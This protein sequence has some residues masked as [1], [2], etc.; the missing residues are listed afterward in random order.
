MAKTL[1]IVFGIVL[2]LV[3]VMGFIPNQFVGA[4]AIFSTNLAHDLV[5]LVSGL[6]LL[7]VAFMAS[8]KSGTWLKILGAVYLLIAVLGFVMTPDGGELLGLVQ[9]NMTD[10]LLHVV[11]GVVLLVAGFVGKGTSAAPMA[12]AAPTPPMGGTM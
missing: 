3:G 8:A 10:H 5:H 7:A 4:G 9:V 1:A 12:P 11:L 6:V 2:V